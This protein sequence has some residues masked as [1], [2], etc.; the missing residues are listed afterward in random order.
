MG[1]LLDN[2]VLLIIVGALGIPA[3]VY[4]LLGLGE[5]ILALLPGQLGRRWRPLV[6]LFLPLALVLL[7]LVYPLV[8]TI[9][10]SVRDARGEGFV[11]LADFAWAFQGEMA[12]VIGNNLL[13]LVA[14]PLGTLALAL[15]AAVL[16]DRVRYERVAVTLIVLPTA[17]SFVAGAVIWTQMYSYQPANSPQRGT[18]N[19]LLTLLIP[20]AKP[21]PWLQTAVVNNFALILIAVWLS[22][23][24]ATLILS[25]AVKNVS[26]ELL[27]A[28]RLDGAGE[29][30]V[31]FSVILPS[32]LPAVLVVL[33]TEIIAALKIFDI[34]Y[35]LTNGNFGTDVI[36]NR[37]YNELFAVNDLGHASAIAVI[38]LVAAMPVVLIN[39]VQ[40]RAET[41]S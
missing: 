27:E 5:R 40:F 11:G 12:D 9:I 16:F 21:V 36:A 41:A 8:A 10:A 13:W 24:I 32:I 20:G 22:L 33:T 26:T 31:F 34:V 39:I 3:V 23:G 37:M 25:A 38:L 1:W 2:A 19:A 17:I 18:F 14:F 29:W 6:W 15:V 30:R 7:I 4:L 28:A 35:V